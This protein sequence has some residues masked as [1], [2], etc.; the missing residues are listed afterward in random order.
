MSRP[1][2]H[3]GGSSGGT[4]GRSGSNTAPGR[5]PPSCR[6]LTRLGS[7]SSRRRGSCRWVRADGGLWLYKNAEALDHDLPFWQGR[8]DSGLGFERLSE[9]ELRQM[10][11][12]VSNDWKAA[13][14]EPDWHYVRNPYKVVAGDAVG[15][16]GRAGG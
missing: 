12:A 5:S 9:D 10:E 7:P 3:S 1:C 15:G 6:P 8:K 13:V 4:A 11:P 16:G 14:L 2:C